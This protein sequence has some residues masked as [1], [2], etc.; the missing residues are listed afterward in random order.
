[1]QMPVELWTIEHTLRSLVYEFITNGLR[2]KCICMND[3]LTKIFLE[4]LDVLVQKSNEDI[5]VTNRF[6]NSTILHGIP[7]NLRC[8]GDGCCNEKW[9]SILSKILDRFPLNQLII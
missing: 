5:F 4:I 9:L 7:C 2:N 8:P 3:N 1:M 6:N